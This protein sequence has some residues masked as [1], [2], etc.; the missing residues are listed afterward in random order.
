[1]FKTSLLFLALSGV[2]AIFAAFVPQLRLTLFGEGLEQFMLYGVVGLALFGAIHYLAPRLTGVENDR[3]VCLSG[4]MITIGILIYA[5]A[6]LVGGIFQ[7]HKLVSSVPFAEVM[8]STK[9][10]LRLS[11]IGILLLMI[12]NA[13]ILWRVAG[14]LREW[15]RTCCKCCCAEEMPVKL[16]PAE[17]AR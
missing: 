3:F 9:M 8:N 12:G 14:L 10:F 6:F 15:C 7:Q 2:F 11:T 4:R 13:A 17:A 16:K 1:Y 5:G